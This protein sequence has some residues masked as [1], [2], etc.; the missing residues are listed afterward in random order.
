MELELQLQNILQ[1]Y[2]F[3]LAAQ[4]QSFPTIHTTYH[5]IFKHSVVIY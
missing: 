4:N 5:K 2:F 3:A 1:Q